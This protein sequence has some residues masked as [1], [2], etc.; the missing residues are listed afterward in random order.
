MHLFHTRPL[1]RLAG[2]ALALGLL[3]TAVVGTTT[4]PAEARPAPEKASRL[5]TLRDW[6]PRKVEI[7]SA[8]AGGGHHTTA[9]YPEPFPN[10]PAY[11]AVL[12]EQF[13]SLTPENQMKWNYIHPEPDRYDFAQADAIVAFAEDNKQV[14]R[15]HTLFWHSQ[16]PEWLKQGDYSPE[17]LRTIL[18]DHVETVVGRYAGRIQQ[19]DE[20]NEIF[21]DSGNL[22]TQDNIWIRELGPGIVADVFR[23]AHAADPKA[24]LFL[25]DYDVEGPNAKSDAYYALVQELLADDVPVH[26]F[27]MQAHRGLQYGFD[28]RMRANLQRFDDLGLATALTEIDVRG[29][30]GADG[31]L[32]PELRQR[33]ADWYSR[34]LEACLAGERRWER[35]G[36]TLTCGH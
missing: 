14:V 2:S 10:D 32:S 8:V 29:P 4:A 3:T 26:G 13:S 23:W 24:E 1:R 35:V 31:Q 18:K 34:A 16:N 33:Q 28:G 19:W 21:D 5:D 36:P 7:G 20:A 22:R 9:D 6:A 15:G 25:N 11:R 27:G 17:E 12:A 30:V